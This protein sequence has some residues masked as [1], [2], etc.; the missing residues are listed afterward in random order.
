MQF[1]APVSRESVEMR[2]MELSSEGVSAHQ[3]IAVAF[4]IYWV[5]TPRIMLLRNP[6][7]S[8]QKIS[9]STFHLGGNPVTYHVW[10]Q[11]CWQQVLY[12]RRSWLFK[13]TKSFWLTCNVSVDWPRSF[14]WKHFYCVH[15]TNQLSN[16]VWLVMLVN[17]LIMS[18][19]YVMKRLEHFWIDGLLWRR[20]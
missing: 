16:N 13:T 19:N 6:I 2:V 10:I 15:L 1:P 20:Q 8:R 11:M 4:V 12:L 17:L 5:F 7:L 14:V 3:R 9:C 18:R